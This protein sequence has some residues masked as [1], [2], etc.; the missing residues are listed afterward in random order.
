MKKKNN[1]SSFKLLVISL[2]TISVILLA[3]L[4]YLL[5]GN[6]NNTSLNEDMKNNVNK[7]NVV[8]FE[9]NMGTF[10]VE[11]YKD[12]API[13]V[14]NFESYVNEGFYNGLI[15]HRVI[16][17]FMIQGGGFKPGLVKVKTKAPIKIESNNG[18]KNTVGTIAM[19]RTMDPN[20]ATSQFFINLKDN[21]FLDYTK[22]NPGY[23]VFGKVISGM[24]VV[25]KIEA[26]QTGVSGSYKDVPVKDVVIEK[27]YIK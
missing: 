15:F 13:T 11:L 2:S 16:K 1:N 25:K 9:T 18:L 8:V 14:K 6:T 20:S 26:V 23:A 3:I 5:V 10:K 21:S 19:A 27:A 7:G 17:D 22:S 4:V 24:D 12:K